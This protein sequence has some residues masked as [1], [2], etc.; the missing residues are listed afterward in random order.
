MVLTWDELTAKVSSLEERVEKLE[1]DNDL[2]R[3]AFAN[4]QEEAKAP[5]RD[6]VEAEAKRKQRR[7]MW[8]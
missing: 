4:V 5:S 6:D 8:D 2:L 1:R 7:T 3:K